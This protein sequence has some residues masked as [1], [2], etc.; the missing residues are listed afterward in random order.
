MA[1]PFPERLDDVYR[2]AVGRDCTL[3]ERLN[4]IADT[5]RN[6]A[7]AFCNEVDLF[8]GR[9]EAARAGDTAPK[10]GEEDRGCGVVG[11]RP[12]L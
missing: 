10:V 8:V 9:L 11:N 6:E 7:P 5:V 4:A 2:D 12:G 3:A 1:R